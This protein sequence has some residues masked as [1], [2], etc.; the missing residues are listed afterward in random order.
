MLVEHIYIYLTGE[1]TVYEKMT[2]DGFLSLYDQSEPT[3][4]PLFFITKVLQGT[5]FNLSTYIIQYHSW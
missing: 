4:L 3:I 1:K 2:K 5:I